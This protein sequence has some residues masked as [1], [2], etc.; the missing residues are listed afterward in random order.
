MRTDRAALPEAQAAFTRRALDVGR[1]LTELLIGQ[2][3]DVSALRKILQRALVCGHHI[4]RLHPWHVDLVRSAEL[5]QRC[6]AV[7]NAAI[8]QPRHDVIDFIQ[9]LQRQKA[10]QLAMQCADDAE[11]A[12]ARPLLGLNTD[13]Q[14]RRVLDDEV[15]PWPA[16]E[17]NVTH[18]LR[19]LDR[20]KLRGQEYDVLLCARR[21]GCNER[22][23][24]PAAMARLARRVKSFCFMVSSLMGG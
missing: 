19:F 21:C 18:L 16:L 15:R 20:T 11:R 7:G 4:G 17:E 24:T 6:N 5:A 9:R 10:G 3:V 23:A 13:V 22:Q 14:A 12:S 1:P 2:R 8:L